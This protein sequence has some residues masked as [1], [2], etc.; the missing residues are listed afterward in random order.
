MSGNKPT[1]ECG[2]CR[3][4]KQRE[5]LRAWRAANRERCREYG[6]K[7]AEKVRNDPQK[8]AAYRERKAR[9]K[10][11]LRQREPER[12]RECDR[13]RAAED[14]KRRERDRERRDAAYWRWYRASTPERQMKSRAR[15]RVRGE[16][17][18]GRMT[19]QPCE[20]CGKQAQAHHD[21]Y[22]RPLDV[23][24]LCRQHHF[25]IHRKDVAA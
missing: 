12:I 23:R 19:R 15:A 17:R 3:V 13:Q 25:E 5:Y 1:C 10:R 24:W 14:E 21:D 11:E 6:R 9:E 22:S 16:I 7:Q 18:A 20:V 2:T 4:C 8:L